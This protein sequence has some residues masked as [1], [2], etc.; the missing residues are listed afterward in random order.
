MI[1]KFED[2]SQI[3]SLEKKLNDIMEEIKVEPLTRDQFAN[4]CLLL[5]AANGY[6]KLPIAKID[7]GLDAEKMIINAIEDDKLEGCVAISEDSRTIKAVA[8]KKNE[9]S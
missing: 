9:I 2:E 6:K 1:L 7:D 8:F 3:H 5:N 4:V